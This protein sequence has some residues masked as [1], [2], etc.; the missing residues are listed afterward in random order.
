M[1]HLVRAITIERASVHLS[2]GMYKVLLSAMSGSV[3]SVPCS[4]SVEAGEE[5][6]IRMI[7]P[8]WGYVICEECWKKSN[9]NLQLS[10]ERERG[11]GECVSCRQDIQD[12]I[13]VRHGTNSCDLEYRRC[14]SCERFVWSN[15]P[16]SQDDGV[17]PNDLVVAIE[18]TE[19]TF[20]AT[21]FGAS[22]DPPPP[23]D[24]YHVARRNLAMDFYELHGC[25]QNVF[26]EWFEAVI[27]FE[28]DKL[29]GP[30]RKPV[31]RG[32]RPKKSTAAKRREP[33]SITETPEGYPECPMCKKQIG[34]LT[35]QEER[36]FLERMNRPEN[37]DAIITEE[38]AELERKRFHSA[39]HRAFVEEEARAKSALAKSESQARSE[40]GE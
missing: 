9:P 6:R 32:G 12:G 17:D 24:Y 40:V 15:D 3:R 14:P 4:S 20:K 19:N 1:V 27:Q 11:F 29:S 33:L 2:A 7:H 13:I 34:L 31:R 16:R 35:E 21:V 38:T 30:R 23:G 39:M 37:A 25:A 26:K 8:R 10:A 28:T 36:D 5:E 22:D 18:E